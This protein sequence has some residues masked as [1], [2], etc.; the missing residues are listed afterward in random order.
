MYVERG[1]TS[2]GV[3]RSSRVRSNGM[4]YRGCGNAN[5]EPDGSWYGKFTSNFSSRS[6]VI[7]EALVVTKVIMSLWGGIEQV[8]SSTLKLDA[9]RSW[10]GSE[11][12]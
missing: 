9:D 10:T 4:L 2:T 3:L 6:Q 7:I 1:I 8:Q 12:G 11:V 5:L